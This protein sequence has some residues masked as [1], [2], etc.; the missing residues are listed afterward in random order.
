MPGFFF[1]LALPSARR[2]IKKVFDIVT[3]IAAASR[4]QATGLDQVNT[5]VGS[6]DEMTQCNAALVE[7]TT[8]AAQSL[9]GQAQT[10]ADLVGFFRTGRATPAPIQASVKPAFAV[11]PRPA[12]AA[13]P[14]PVRALAKAP[15]P[16]LAA[17]DD[18]QEF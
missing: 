17:A 5:A 15:A 12:A 6:M 8:A 13:R 2:A 16:A 3:E 14:A 18:W 4:E 10:L 11:A 1:Y 7:E 9:N